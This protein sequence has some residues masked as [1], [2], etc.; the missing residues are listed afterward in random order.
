MSTSG[1][2]ERW[3]MNL[4]VKQVVTNDLK[5]RWVTMMAKHIVK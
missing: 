2:G 5:D 1:H 3:V 4:F